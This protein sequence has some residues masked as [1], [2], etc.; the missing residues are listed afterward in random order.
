ML[1]RSILDSTIFVCHKCDNR[2]CV[3]PNHMFLG[4]HIDNMIDMVKKRR[5]CGGE[6]SHLSKMTED[7]VIDVIEGLLNNTYNCL[8]DV[9]DST[10]VTRHVIQKLLRRKLWKHVTDN[11]SDDQ[12]E[13]CRQ[14]IAQKIKLTPNVIADIKLRTNNG[15]TR[16]SI[17]KLYNININTVSVARNHK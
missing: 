14:K 3:N 4:T 9:V 8:K 5:Y 11:Y 2:C 1:F 13:L 10:C 16:K 12:L 6:N 17:A 15:E 7:D